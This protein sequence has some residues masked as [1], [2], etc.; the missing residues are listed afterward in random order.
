MSEMNR[1]IP[2]SG[3]IFYSASVLLAEVFIF[4]A[5]GSGRGGYLRKLMKP[6]QAGSIQHLCVFA[7]CL[8]PQILPTRL[9][10]PHVN[11]VFTDE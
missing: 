10:S 3:D 2:A 4:S 1:F 11:F 6:C 9:I 5:A 7:S 8:I